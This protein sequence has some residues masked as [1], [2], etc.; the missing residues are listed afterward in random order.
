MGS[1]PSYFKETTNKDTLNATAQLNPAK[2]SVTTQTKSSHRFVNM[3]N[4]DKQKW[5]D[6]YNNLRF[7]SLK[8][9]QKQPDFSL[10]V[11]KTILKYNQKTRNFQ[12]L[13]RLLCG[14]ES[15]E[16]RA[17]TQNL[18]QKMINLAL[19][20]P[21][22]LHDPIAVLNRGKSACIYLTQKQCATILANAF[23]CTFPEPIENEFYP[24]INF[25]R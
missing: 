9:N 18:I 11:E 13:H 24:H 1:L 7:L 8:L 15:L 22:I 19:K 17:Q 5:Q 10:I 3:P 14:H 25:N 12:N 21:D 4:T 20:L 23:F 16:I 6:I 2:E